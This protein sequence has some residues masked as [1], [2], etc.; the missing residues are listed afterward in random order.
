MKRSVAFAALFLVAASAFAQQY[1]THPIRLVVPA[2]PGGGTDMIERWNR[3]LTAAGVQP[4][5]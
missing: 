3:V 5:N 4:T 2:A 1:P